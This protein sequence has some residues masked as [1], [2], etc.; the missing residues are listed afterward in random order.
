MWKLMKMNWKNIGLAALVALIL[1][2]LV[3]GCRLNVEM[4]DAGETG[5]SVIGA[6]EGLLQGLL[7]AIMNVF[8]GLFGAA[9]GVTGAAVGGATEAGGALLRGAGDVGRTT[10]DTTGDVARAGLDTAREAGQAV[11]GGLDTALGGGSPVGYSSHA[12]FAEY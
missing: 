6:G 2:C 1:Y 8:R 12:G 5:E 3:N 9:R 7:N 10:L 4:M 11:V